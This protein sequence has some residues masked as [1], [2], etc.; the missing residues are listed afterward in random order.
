VGTFLAGDD[1]SSGNEVSENLTSGT[2]PAAGG[3]FTNLYVATGSGGNHVHDNEALSLE[4]DNLACGSNAWYG[5]TFIAT[6]SNND[7]SS[8]AGTIGAPRCHIRWSRARVGDQ[9]VQRAC[10]LAWVASTSLTFPRY[11]PGSPPTLP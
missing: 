9:F 10:G 7:G 5:N 8:V 6:F 1:D 4:D 11:S 2:L 3:S